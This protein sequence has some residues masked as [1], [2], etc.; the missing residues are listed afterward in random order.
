MIGVYR[1]HKDPLSNVVQKGLLELESM[2]VTGLPS[3]VENRKDFIIFNAA[4]RVL[5]DDIAKMAVIRIHLVH[6]ITL[7]MPVT[8]V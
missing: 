7:I 5:E 6:I 1:V 4:S 2:G 3:K 8:M